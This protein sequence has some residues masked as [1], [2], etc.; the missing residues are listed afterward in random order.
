MP[1]TPAVT[2]RDKKGFQNQY[3]SLWQAVEAYLDGRML[4]DQMAALENV[5]D[6]MFIA[7]VAQ[8]QMFAQLTGRAK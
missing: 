7:A 6:P 4:P 8:T 2:H 3:G 1:I 5:V